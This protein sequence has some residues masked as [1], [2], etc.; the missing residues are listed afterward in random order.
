MDTVAL[1]TFCGYVFI[2]EKKK[3]TKKLFMFNC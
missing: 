1:E 2:T 3:K